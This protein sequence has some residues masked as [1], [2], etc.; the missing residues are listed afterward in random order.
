MTLKDYIEELQISESELKNKSFLITGASGLIGKELTKELF[1]LSKKKDLNIRLIL[2][3]RNRNKLENSIL[4]YVLEKKIELIESDINE[5][6]E[7]NKPVDYIIHGASIT[8]S[9]AMVEKPVE[10]ICTSIIGTKN[11]LNFA[12]EKNV[13]SV[14]Y[15]SSM[16]VYGFIAEEILLTEDK[17]QY[18][19]PLTLR[20]SYPESKRMCENLCVAYFSEYN[21]PVKIVRL[22]Q[23]FGKGTSK[24]DKRVFAE[25]ARCAFYNK[26]ITLLTDGSSKR[27]YVDTFDV[28]TAITTVLL[29]GNSGEAY[30][31]ANK[32]T[33]CSILDM[34]Y[35]VSNEV[36]ERKIKVN[37]L[38]DNEK[39]KKFPPSHCL[40]LD[41]KRI[42]KLGW[43]A[44]TNLKDM[45]INM[46]KEWKNGN[47]IL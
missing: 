37:L 29:K 7:Y 45:Y 43:R 20:S 42:E 39:N 2:L 13:K 15:L 12:V 41:T 23:T 17:L 16:E 6:I 40:L 32:K 25:F 18:L 35:L 4:K 36:A 22:A 1:D 27:M 3:V 33:Y 44:S 14:V 24:Q 31:V 21:V 30:N 5:K 28:V 19:N 11:I 8:D 47:S 34:A 38:I 26:D 46:I 9:N 10:V